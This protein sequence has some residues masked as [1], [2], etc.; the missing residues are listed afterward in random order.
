MPMPVLWGL[1]MA[2]SKKLVL[3]GMFGLGIMYD[4]KSLFE[5]M[6]ANRFLSIC[7][8]TLIRIKITSENHGSNAQ[9][10]YSLIALFTCLEALLGVINACLPVL[11]PIFNKFSDSR[12]SSWL[13]SVMSGSIPIFMRPS[14]M[15][16][17]FKSHNSGWA[18]RRQS[19]RQ[20]QGMHP[21][22]V[23]NS[24]NEMPK[25]PGSS[26]ISQTRSTPPPP[27]YVENKAAN[28]MFSTAPTFTA[29]R[30]P[31]PTRG[32][33][34]VSVRPPVPPKGSYYSPTKRWEPAGEKDGAAPGIFVQREWDV[35]RG[36]SEET[37]RHLLRDK[38]EED[39]EY[40]RW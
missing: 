10:I 20:S 14:Q 30:S 6:A 38:R 37:D 32:S 40:G 1:Q 23:P 7:V 29:I 19:R 24:E 18:S 36:V 9:Q 34:S 21:M 3:S 12:A 28:M 15:G 5:V 4:L 16:S 39:R 26:P 11:K 33:D 25:W 35:E 13:S 31:P 8:I 22:P 27:R 2:M 17:T